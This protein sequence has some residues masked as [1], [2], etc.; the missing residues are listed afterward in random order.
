MLLPAAMRMDT[1]KILALPMG[2][3]GNGGRCLGNAKAPGWSMA[4][5]NN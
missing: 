3:L 5:K 4:H 1:E 2:E